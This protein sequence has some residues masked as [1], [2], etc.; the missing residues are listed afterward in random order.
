MQPEEKEASENAL[1]LWFLLLNHK[2]RIAVTASS[3]STFDNPDGAHP[4]RSRVYTYLDAPFSWNRLAERMRAGRSFVTTGPLIDFRIDGRG[5]G[6]TVT[7]SKQPIFDAELTAWASGEAGA[8]L[9]KIEVFW[10]GAVVRTFSPSQR[11]RKF[12]A[13]FPLEAPEDG[14]FVVRC[15]GAGRTRA[16]T[17]PIYFEAGDHR[18]PKPVPAQINLQVRRE[19]TGEPL[20]GVCEVI[21]MVGRS[22]VKQSEMRIVGGRLRAVVPATARLRLSVPGFTP[23]MRSIFLD[24]GLLDLTANLNVD[25]ML[26]WQTFE[27]IKSML[28]EINFDV[29]L[30]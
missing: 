27:N 14:W 16:I 8:S 25:Q 11:N 22:A 17:N 18:R 7:L 26:E 29:S 12:H 21:Q 2:Y 10:N 1:R 30:A 9:A 4:G 19:Q 6:E 24:T 23:V 13:H 28:G 3:D 15:H 20:S 5:P